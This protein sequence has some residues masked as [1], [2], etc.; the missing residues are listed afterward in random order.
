MVS[1][2]T[3]AVKVLNTGFTARVYIYAAAI[4]LLVSTS[5]HPLVL[6]K[7]FSVLKIVNLVFNSTGDAKW[8]QLH[9]TL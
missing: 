3:A 9:I 1:L 6:G 7:P 5:S 8:Q 2:V 4:L